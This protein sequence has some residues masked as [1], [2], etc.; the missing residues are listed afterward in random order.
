MISFASLLK[1]AK[2]NK[3]GKDE[4]AA[5]LPEVKTSAQLAKMPDDRYLSNMTRCVFRAGFSWK[6]IDKKWPDFE[7][8]FGG[9][10]PYPIAHYSDERL[11]E[12]VQE[13]RIV[14][15]AA[16]IKSVRD[17]AVF[18][19]DV[20]ESHGSFAK[21]IADWPVSDITGLW[22]EL[23]K[24][25]SRLGGNSGPMSLRMAGKDTFLLSGDVQ[26]ALVNHKLV[27]SLNPNTKRDLASVQEVFNRFQK[28]SG[29]PLS[30]ISRIMALTV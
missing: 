25:G 12:L 7:T 1:L 19:C 3:G 30:H 28:E 10:A 26:A 11:E 18:V 14:R 4:L 16:K 27:D 17:N 24:R 13:K 29:Y 21:Y 6:V 9:F 8:V 23:K 20:Q 2:K 22:L 15:H 5:I